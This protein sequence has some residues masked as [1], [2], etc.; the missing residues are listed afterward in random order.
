MVS[1]NKINYKILAEQLQHKIF[2]LENEIKKLNE[3]MYSG[4]LYV[5]NEKNIG[6]QIAS[7]S[8]PFYTPSNF[9]Y[10]SGSGPG[11]WG[12]FQPPELCEPGICPIKIKPGWRANEMDD[13]SAPI[14]PLPNRPQGA[15][16]FEGS[17][18][19][20]PPIAPPNRPRGVDGFEGSAPRTPTTPPRNR[21]RGVDGFEGSAPRGPLPPKPNRP[22]GAEQAEN[23]GYI[24]PNTGPRFGGTDPYADNVM[25]NKPN[26]TGYV[27]SKSSM[28]YVHGS[29]THY[30]Y[31]GEE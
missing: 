19:R 18:P 14:P 28:F 17:A 16:G 3:S 25:F 22:R 21:P 26:P 2:N 10:T 13:G 9:A 24:P 23:P 1:M 6:N 5:Y 12:D 11:T 31:F 8:N 30:N 27:P 29:T 15:E 7:F 4:D 20:T